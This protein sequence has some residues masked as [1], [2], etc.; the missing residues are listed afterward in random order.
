MTERGIEKC[1]LAL[2]H[3][4]TTAD[5]DQLR[6]RTLAQLANDVQSLKE[7]KH[8]IRADFRR[9]FE[10]WRTEEA[11]PDAPVAAVPSDVQDVRVYRLT[12]VFALLCEVGLAAWIFW[13]LGVSWWLGVLTAIGITFT[14]HGV[15]LHL[16]HNP[17]RPKETVYRIKRYVSTPAALGLLMALGAAMLARYVHGAL[18]LALLP[19]FSLSLWL[20]TMSLLMLAASLFTLAHLWGWSARHAEHYR[21]V[22]AE[23]RAS[24]DFLGEL[25]SRGDREAKPVP[26]PA[27][28]DSKVIDGLG[29]TAAMMLLVAFLGSN[30]A[31]TRPVTMAA[32]QND[33][34]TVVAEQVRAT[35]LHIYI[36]A[37]GS[38]V[39]TA[40]EE[41]WNNLRADLPAIME[42]FRIT[43]LAIW[44]FDE[45]GW[46]PR[47]IVEVSLPALMI[48]A[49]PVEN[50]GEWNSFANIRTAV[51][52][53]AREESDRLRKTARDRYR[54]ALGQ[55]LLHFQSQEVLPAADHKTAC[56]DVVGLLARLSE[57][58]EA[59]RQ[60]AIVITDLADTRHHEL[61]VIGAPAG[62]VQALVLF[63][64]AQP[65]DAALAFGKPLSGSEQFEARAGELRRAAPWMKIAPHFQKNIARLF[66]PGE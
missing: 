56:T 60:F 59:G 33:Q 15:L 36:D 42:R 55:S 28:P 14:L 4:G 26:S 27:K 29:I 18:A 66:A 20:G 3:A 52:A 22:D 53:A 41:A 23:E 8:A 37:S 35:P 44:H 17:E 5:R 51:E 21:R 47:R 6:A 54:A 7:S 65:K 62:E 12:A 1:R 10:R 50:A 19:V 38:C 25:E 40:L 34:A 39:R 30:T 24:T 46:S 45:D 57:P 63:A 48:P 64:P 43:Q 58:G 13:R 49:R 32:E 16:F 9:Q 31:C 2:V 11:P 61:P